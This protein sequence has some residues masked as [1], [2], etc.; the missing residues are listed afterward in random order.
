[1]A[2]ADGGAYRYARPI[3]F[4]SPTN[5]AA[6]IL[7]QSSHPRANYT[8][9]SMH[10]LLS[11]KERQVLVLKVYMHLTLL[12]LSNFGVATNGIVIATEKKSSSLLIDSSM[13][14]KVAVICPNIGI[15]YSGMGPDFRTLVNKARK[16]AQAYWKIYGEYPPTRVLTQEI[17]SVMQ[18]ATQSG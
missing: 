7:L 18:G 3:F 11:L 12:N 6:V 4:G 16:S 14:E 5:S 10:L 9:L 13:I 2:S 8:R 17:A 1:M 15:V